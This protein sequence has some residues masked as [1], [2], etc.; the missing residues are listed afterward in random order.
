MYAAASGWESETEGLEVAESEGDDKQIWAQQRRRRFY[1]H[2]VTAE[3][4]GVCFS[5]GVGGR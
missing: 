3:G 5:V 2:A 4:E 1:R